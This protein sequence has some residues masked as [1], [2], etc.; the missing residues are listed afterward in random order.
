MEYNQKTGGIVDVLPYFMGDVGSLNRFV[1]G[2]HVLWLG[3]RQS[4][5]LS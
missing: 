2:D 1:L 3:R 4:V 5:R